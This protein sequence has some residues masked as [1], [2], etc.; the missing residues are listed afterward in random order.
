[1]FSFPLSI[2][3]LLLSSRQTLDGEISLSTLTPFGAMEIS[4]VIPSPGNK[5]HNKIDIYVEG[6]KISWLLDESVPRSFG[7]TLVGFVGEIVSHVRGLPVNTPCRLNVVFQNESGNITL[8]GHLP[9]CAFAS[10][11]G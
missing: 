9:P 7:N 10:A 4:F 6:D 5:T 3:Y 2:P 1:M 11:N 8:A